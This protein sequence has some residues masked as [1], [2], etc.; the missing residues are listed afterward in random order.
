MKRCKRLFSMLLAVITVFSFAA[1]GKKPVDK[2]DEA[3]LPEETAPQ[4]PDEELPAEDKAPAEE[5]TPSVPVPE[6]NPD[7]GLV[8]D[9]FVLVSSVDEV[10][11]RPHKIIPGSEIAIHIYPSALYL[12]WFVSRKEPVLKN[13]FEGLVYCYMGKPENV[14][15]LIA[16]SWQVSDDYLTWTFRIR[17]GIKFTDGTICDAAAIAESWDY[18]S[19]YGFALFSVLNIV[20][21][22]ATGED[23]LSVQLSAPCAHFESSL[24]ELYVISPAA[25]KEWGPENNRAAVGTAPYYIS[26]F[27]ESN[28]YGE[29]P[30]EVVF[31]AN[32]D[33][34]LYERMPAI[35]TIR[36]KTWLDHDVAEEALLSGEIDAYS[37]SYVYNEEFYS[38][39]ESEFDGT[40]LKA[41]DSGAL[42]LFNPTFVPELQIYEVRKAINRFID[43]DA[44]NNA[45]YNGMGK[46][47]TSIWAAGTSGA[48]P[49][50]EGFYYAPEEGRE[51]LAEAGFEPGSISFENAVVDTNQELME[52]IAD[53]LAAGGIEMKLEIFEAHFGFSPHPTDYR[54]NVGNVGYSDTDPYAPWQFIL[55]EGQ[56][57]HTVRTDLYDPELYATQSDV[58]EKLMSSTTWEEMLENSKT[59]TDL[60]QKDYAALP[61]VSSPWF[62]AVSKRL[63]GAVVVSEQH[64]LLWNYLY[65]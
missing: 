17:E 56:L 18:C 36:G 22:E 54:L 14:R 25:L 35:E 32:P 13:I 49:W 20:S 26:E 12:P 6:T 27:A 63:K 57:M 60:V 52:M 24:A 11:A 45:L 39:L 46:V 1:C 40:V 21:W 44:I 19:Q 41:Y 34:Y 7:E 48:V 28:E 3:V 9:E 4:T 29:V 38:R 58:Y 15:P 65:L 62:V 2:F 8:P 53:Q 23:E 59:L 31:T 37:F 33:Y 5:E 55:L 10:L 30:D 42:L 61:G 16:E 47:Q 43:L 50:P 51:L 64:V